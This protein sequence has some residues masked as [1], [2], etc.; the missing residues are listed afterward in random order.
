MA[1][2]VVNLVNVLAYMDV[3]FA[4]TTSASETSS[5][6]PMNVHSVCAYFRS[7]SRE[8]K[9][10]AKMAE[11]AGIIPSRLHNTGAA[12]AMS[13]S[14]CAIELT[15]SRLVMTVVREPVS[16]DKARM[17]LCGRPTTNAIAAPT[18]YPAAANIAL[19]TNIFKVM[20]RKMN[21]LPNS[22]T[23]T[24]NTTVHTVNTGIRIQQTSYSSE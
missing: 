7:R 23:M 17:R 20:Q 16:I 11:N 8:T 22:V 10:R 21:A 6:D 5:C 14:G 15:S 24:E 18:A 12:L 2:Y 1:Q 4:A 19:N 13:A 9:R 3:S